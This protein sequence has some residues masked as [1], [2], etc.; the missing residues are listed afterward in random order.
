V[1][2]R[3]RVVHYGPAYSGIIHHARRWG[4]DLIVIG[5]ERARYG[6]R[7]AG[8]SVVQRLLRHAACDLLTGPG[9]LGRDNDE[10]LAA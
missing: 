5:K 2:A 1:E 9:P 6:R 7:F 4:A 10:R 3:E 8:G